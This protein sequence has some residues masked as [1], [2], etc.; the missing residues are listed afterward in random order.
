[1]TQSS[2]VLEQCYQRTLLKNKEI[3][4]MASEL[5]LKFNILTKPSFRISTKIQLHNLYKTSAAK[6]WTNSSFQINKL[7]PRWFSV[8]TSARV[9]ISTSFELVFSHAR[10][11]SIKF[12]KEQLVSQWVSDK[13]KQWSDSGPIKMKILASLYPSLSGTISISTLLIF[14]PC[15]SRQ[16]SWEP[17]QVLIT[18]KGLL[19][20]FTWEVLA[21][22]GVS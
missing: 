3:L 1:M 7:L 16:A 2:V 6:C 4:K 19:F 20:S 22:K 17:G 15:L 11:T 14:L 8:S 21:S 10:V 5:N 9:T 13:S 18:F 12:T